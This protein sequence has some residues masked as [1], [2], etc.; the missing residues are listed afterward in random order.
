MRGSLSGPDGRKGNSHLKGF[1]PET[2]QSYHAAV[3]DWSGTR[4]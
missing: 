3:T 1:G 2:Q 4:A